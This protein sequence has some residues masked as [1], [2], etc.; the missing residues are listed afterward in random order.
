MENQENRPAST[1]SAGVPADAV[2]AE[3]NIF[4]H[5]TSD[6]EVPLAKAYRVRIDGQEVRV[7]TPRPT[8]EL[9]LGKVGKRR[10]HS[11]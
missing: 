1:P 8:G 5:A 9:L 7:D 4:E 11:S 6:K 3:V 10:A 2:D